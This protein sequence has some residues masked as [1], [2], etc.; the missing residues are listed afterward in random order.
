MDGDSCFDWGC[1]SMY[2]ETHMGLQKFL[3][4]TN[5]FSSVYFFYLSQFIKYYPRD[6]LSNLWIL[7]LTPAHVLLRR[8][9]CSVLNGTPHARNSCAWLGGLFCR[10]DSG[11]T[12]LLIHHPIGE[13]RKE[14]ALFKLIFLPLQF[15]LEGVE[16]WTVRKAGDAT[17]LLL[18]PSSS[19]F[20]PS[21]KT[22]QFLRFCVSHSGSSGCKITSKWT[23]L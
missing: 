6:L 18:F 3:L 4:A 11:R 5:R 17:L 10:P 7:Y 8:H 21:Q 15:G 2:N 20:A 13:G 12:D 16:W 22:G 1:L 9:W 14:M 19:V 23:S